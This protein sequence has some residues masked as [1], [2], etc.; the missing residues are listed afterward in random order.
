MSID[1]AAHFAKYLAGGGGGGDSP[2][3]VVAISL[4]PS[5]CHSVL[6]PAHPHSCW[7]LF[8]P[9]RPH[10]HLFL[11]VLIWPTLIRSCCTHSRSCHCPCLLLPLALAGC[12]SC[13]L[14]H[15]CARSCW[16]SSGLPLFV[17][18]LPAL[19]QCCPHWCSTHPRSL[20][21]CPGSCQ[22]ALTSAHSCWS[23]SGSSSFIRAA[24]GF[25]TGMEI[26]AV[27]G[28]RVT[29]VRVRCVNLITVAIPYPYLRYR[30]Y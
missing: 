4:M 5:R 14:A 2:I 16:S 21:Q 18:A 24:L 30:G 29:R 23:S 8:L 6:I 1:V 15:T 11:L 20:V 17:C 9:A 3:A 7:L 28:P 22:V 10:L 27:F 26:P 13:Q 19:V 25:R 12:H